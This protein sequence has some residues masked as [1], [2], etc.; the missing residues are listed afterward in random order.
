MQQYDLICIGGGSGGIATA[1]RAAEYGAKVAVIEQSRLGGTCVNVGCVPKKMF[2][3]AAHAAQTLRDA[4]LYGLNEIPD[5]HFNWAHF[6]AARDANIVR[7]NGI[8]AKNLDN[9]NVDLYRGKA[10]FTDAHH[11]KVGE[12]ILEAPH[13]VIATG[14]HPIIPPIAGAEYGITS[15]DYFALDAQP[16][17]AVIVGGGYIACELSGTLQALGTDCELVV[18]GE[19]VLRHQLDS[20]ITDALEEAMTEQGIQLR[21]NAQITS[22]EKQTSGQLEITFNNGE[23]TLTDTLLWATGRAPNTKTLNLEA[24]GVEMTPKGIIPV[25]DYQNTNVPGIYALGDVIGR[26]DLTPVAIAAGRKLAARLFN[27]QPDAK[28]DYQNVPT[29]MFTHPPIGVVG[30]TESK[31]KQTFPAA[32]IKIYHAKF[33]PMARTFSQHKPKTVLKLICQGKNEKIIGI[34][35]IGDGVDEMLEGFAVAVKMGATKADFDDTVA[36][37]PTSAEELVTM[38]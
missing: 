27:H 6:K 4:S 18:R 32:E 28:L 36:I 29:V 21:L 15:D 1:R 17:H 34:E 24:A 7:L 8:Y 35:M 3:Y 30:Y 38:R 11:V 13:I 19:R 14:G 12:D 26:I 25:D 22:I 10:E 23:K 20:D 9:A 16:K 2:W 33:T 31:A 5:I 37:H